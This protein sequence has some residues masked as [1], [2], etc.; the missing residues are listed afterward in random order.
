MRSMSVL[1]AA[2]SISAFTF[3]SPALA[4]DLKIGAGAAP[5]EN[6]LKPVKSAFEAATGMKLYIV[7]S[8]PKNAF[9]DLEKGDLDAAAAGLSYPD[10]LALMKK[11][12]SEVKEP[13][14]FTPVLIGKDKVRVIVNKENKIKSLS[15]E[16]IQGIFTGE[17]QS[18]K[19]VGGEDAPI[20][21]VLGKLTPG[22]N[23]MFQKKFLPGKEFAKDVLEAT[24]AEDVRQNV[25][26]NP[27]AVAFGPLS[28]LDGSIGA[29]ETPELARDITLITKGKPAAKV[30]KL[31]DFIKGPGRKFIK[32]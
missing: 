10:W 18:W 21:V 31:L 16:Q 11:E 29:P 3:A 5:T 24:T 8:G 27:S 17:L 32:E 26:S 20:L 23:S 28:L 7:S 4:E 30:Q 25:V 6:I 2:M 13:A 15:S 1:L 22:T 19:D 12:G 14:A 9:V